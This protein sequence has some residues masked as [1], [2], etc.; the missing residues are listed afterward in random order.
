MFIF[1]SQNSPAKQCQLLQKTDTCMGY[2]H[3]T[4]YTVVFTYT[5]MY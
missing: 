4:P 3:A 2:C 5:Y 1:R